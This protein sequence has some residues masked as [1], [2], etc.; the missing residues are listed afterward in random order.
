MTEAGEAIGTRMTSGV[1]C[2]RNSVA[3]PSIV[4]LWLGVA[5]V[6][7]AAPARAQATT[8]S[9]PASLSVSVAYQPLW[10]SRDSQWFAAG[11]DLEVAGR[12][13]PGLDIFGAFGTARYA[14]GT[15]GANVQLSVTH[16]VG[17]LRVRL[18][19]A[20]FKPFLQASLGLG[21]LGVSVEANGGNAETGVNG[22]VAEAGAGVDCAVNGVLSIRWLG[23]LR[24][25]WAGGDGSGEFRTELGLVFS[26]K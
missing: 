10:H 17:G 16:V 15:A 25:I 1:A 7:A 5:C 14:T 19:S 20:R 11:V 23:G 21:R 13:R 3:L 9:K 2:R 24:H 8:E 18:G 26:V 12:P 4:T 6:G 22:R